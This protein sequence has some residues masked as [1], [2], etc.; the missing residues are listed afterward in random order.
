MK[1]KSFISASMVVL[2]MLGISNEP[3]ASC[4]L[5]DGWLCGTTA[6]MEFIWEQVW[7]P[8]LG[9]EYCCS[10]SIPMNACNTAGETNQEIC[11]VLR[12]H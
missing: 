12:V 4:D 10:A 11:G 7:P 1:K 5:P 3:K 8:V 6:E 2:L 9:A